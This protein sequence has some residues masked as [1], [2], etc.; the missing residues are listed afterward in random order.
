M[1]HPPQGL[2]KAGARSIHSLTASLANAGLRDP[3]MLDMHPTYAPT[4]EGSP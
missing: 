1:M 3:T 2:N 4:D